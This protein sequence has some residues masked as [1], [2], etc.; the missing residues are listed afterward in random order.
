MGD[1]VPIYQLYQQPA[2]PQ[3]TSSDHEVVA[4]WRLSAMTE[5]DHTRNNS[6]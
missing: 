5:V 4:T 1:P 6:R 2:K 3:L